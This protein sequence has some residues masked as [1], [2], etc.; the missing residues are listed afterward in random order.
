VSNS[1]CRG[2]T[3]ELYREPPVTAAEERVK[4]TDWWEEGGATVYEIAMVSVRWSGNTGPWVERL[5]AAV[6]HQ[7]I[8]RADTVQ[9][10]VDWRQPVDD[11]VYRNVSPFHDLYFYP[12]STHCL[13]PFTG[14]TVQQETKA[15]S[16]MARWRTWS[17]RTWSCT[18]QGDSGLR[19]C[20]VTNDVSEI[21]LSWKDSSSS[22]GWGQA[23]MT[24]ACGR[25]YQ[26][27]RMN[28]G[29]GRGYITQSDNRY[30]DLRGRCIGLQRYLLPINRDWQSDD[31]GSHS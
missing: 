14:N 19:S 31:K 18:D 30:V 27:Y 1:K 15:R 13:S 6:H 9:L 23:V 24:S 12:V 20:I 25:M 3:C 2:V 29:Q 5:S 4:T 7:V 17:G 10:C 16:R 22:G 26:R 21:E 8:I 28:Q 11:Y